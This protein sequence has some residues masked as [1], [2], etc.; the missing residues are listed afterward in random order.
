LLKKA[1]SRLR[2]PRHIAFLLR[3]SHCARFL[4]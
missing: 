2:F 4:Q 3:P 1:P